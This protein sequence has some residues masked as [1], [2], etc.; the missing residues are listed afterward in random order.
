M[1]QSQS[2][3]VKMKIQKPKGDLMEM[4]QSL[5]SIFKPSEQNKHMYIFKILRQFKEHNNMF[6][7][8]M[9]MDKSLFKSS[10]IKDVKKTHSDADL[11]MLDSIRM[12]E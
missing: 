7:L 6:T 9:Q 10:C 11:K 4:A 12:L 2:G 3:T 8:F 1:R 5:N